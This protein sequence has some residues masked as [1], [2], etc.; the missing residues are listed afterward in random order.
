MKFTFTTVYY[1][2]FARAPI[3][4][5]PWSSFSQVGGCARL[6]PTGI[7]EPRS[8]G[9]NTWHLIPESFRRLAYLIEAYSVLHVTLVVP[10]K[11]PMPLTAHARGRL[12]ASA[13]TDVQKLLNIDRCHCMLCCLLLWM[14]QI[15]AIPREIVHSASMAMLILRSEMPYK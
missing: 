11:P 3:P 9:P 4:P 6:S 15:I 13:T 10:V 8:A 1:I 7:A 14:A 12:S 2:E 5:P